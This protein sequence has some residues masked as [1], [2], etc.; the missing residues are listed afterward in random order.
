MI[1]YIIVNSVCKNIQTS[2]YNDR[3]YH[4]TLAGTQSLA[5]Q[6]EHN[7]HR[8]RPEEKEDAA[9]IADILMGKMIM[10]I[11]EKELDR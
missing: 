5:C 9:Y 1:C 6:R 11:S 10:L 4:I 2:S 3:S 8:I 7:A